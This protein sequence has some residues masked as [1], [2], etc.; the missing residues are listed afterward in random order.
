LGTRYQSRAPA[1]SFWGVDRGV[2]RTY[3]VGMTDADD[4]FAG[5]PTSVPVRPPR[6]HLSRSGWLTRLTIYVA[7]VQT[8]SALAIDNAIWSI[9]P[10][11]DSLVSLGFWLYLPSAVADAVLCILCLASRRRSLRTFAVVALGLVVVQ[12]A[13]LAYLFVKFATEPAPW[14][15]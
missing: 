13:L 4:P 9:A 6:Q 11:L 10:S 12:F 5:L 1:T 8:L 2:R 15:F 14:D 3:A 7:V